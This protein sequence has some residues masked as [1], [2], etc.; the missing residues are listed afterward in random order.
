MAWPG[1][2]IGGPNDQEDAYEYDGRAWVDRSDNFFT[3]EIAINWNAAL[4]YALAAWPSVPAAV[5][6]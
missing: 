4:I 2:L 5:E 1:L 3:N 6:E